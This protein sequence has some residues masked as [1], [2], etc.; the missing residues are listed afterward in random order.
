MSRQL[1]IS[2]V[3]LVGNEK[4]KVLYNK[5]KDMVELE[6]GGTTLRFEARNFFMMN[7]MMRKAAAKLVMQTELHHV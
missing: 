6:I 2:Q 4:C 1:I 3:K 5:D 7:E